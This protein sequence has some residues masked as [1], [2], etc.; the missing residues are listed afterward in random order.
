[1]SRF[2]HSI[3]FRLFA[4]TF[5]AMLV[6]VGVLLLVLA[7]GFSTFYEQRQKK[8]IAADLNRLRD[9]YAVDLQLTSDRVKSPLYFGPFVNDYAADLVMVTLRGGLTDYT[10]LGG[11]HLSSSDG[12]PPGGEPMTRIYIGGKGDSSKEDSSWYV[13]PIGPSPGTTGELEQAVNRWRSDADAFRQVMVQGKTIVYRESGGGSEA[14]LIAVA[15]ISGDGNG[16]GQALFA[17]SSLQPVTHASSVFKDLS[18][19]VFAVAFGLVGLL[20]VGYAALVTRP[21]RRLNGIAARLARLDF[22]A[23]SGWKRK[24]EIGDLS[25]TFDF[26]AD[27]LQQTLAELTSANE[28]LRQDIEN[29]KRLE[30]MRR[31]FVAGVSHEL[32]TPLSLIVGYAEGL[33]DNIAGAKRERYA[34]VILEETQRMSAIVADLLDLSHLESGRYALRKEPFDAGELVREAGEQARTLGA[35]KRLR[36]VLSL[37]EAETAAAAEAGAKEAASAVAAAEREGAAATASVL[38][39]VIADRKRIGQVLTNLVSNAV[40]HAPEE[41]VVELGLRVA[42]REVEWFVRNEGPR[43]PEEEL[44]RIWEPFFRGDKARSREQGGTGIGLAVVKQIIELH[45]GR[46][47]AVNLPDGVEFRFALPLSRAVR[48]A[49]A[50]G[51]PAQPG[52]AGEQAREFPA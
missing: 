41:G 28:K 37:P 15:A 8:D 3:A 44:P 38:A 39:V 29:E 23:R 25:R 40:R 35:A 49:R 36:V 50:D 42:G 30:K 21:L 2:R 33:K 16:N 10:F 6:F 51:P 7:S 45:E 17:V 12:L 22:S 14:R 47:E 19:Y 20:A 34:D 13:L 18:W 9:R 5:A 11:Q 24:D 52:P 32:K 31:E 4:V 27:N 48:S 1:M 46:C 43:I 26:L